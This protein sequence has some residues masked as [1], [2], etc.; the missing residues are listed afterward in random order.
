MAVQPD[1]DGF[2]ISAMQS[3]LTL[4]NLWYKRPWAEIFTHMLTT[5]IISFLP[6]F[7][8]LLTDG[9]AAK[10]FIEGTNYTK[11]VKNLSDPAFHENCV[12]V[13]RFITFHPGQEIKYEEVSCFEKDRIWGTVA[14]IL[15]FLPGWPIAMKMST[16][17]AERTKKDYA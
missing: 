13:G 16:T 11:Y 15:I 7:Y 3:E 5:L 2:N 1:D 4:E 17:I 6:T 8:D 10:S 14:A 12:H 9:F